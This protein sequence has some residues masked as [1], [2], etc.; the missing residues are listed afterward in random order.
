MDFSRDA[1]SASTGVF[2]AQCL[3]GVVCGQAKAHDW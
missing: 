1:I 3:Y 2:D